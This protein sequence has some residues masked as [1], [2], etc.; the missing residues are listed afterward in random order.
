MTQC[1]F[2][3]QHGPRTPTWLLATAGITDINMVFCSSPDH[4]H[5]HGLRWPL[6]TTWTTDTNIVPPLVDHGAG[7]RGGL[8]VQSFC[9]FQAVAH[10]PAPLFT[11]VLLYLLLR[12]RWLIRPDHYACSLK[13]A[14]PLCSSHG[15]ESSKSNR[16][17][18]YMPKAKPLAQ[19][20]QPQALFSNNISLCPPWPCSYPSSPPPHRY[21]CFSPLHEEV[22][23]GHLSFKLHEITF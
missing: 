7:V 3:W 12:N 17:S 14:A 20:N 13:K 1:D 16:S 2:K 10:H 21:L 11:T 6:E 22:T 15:R 8:E 9:E 5:E 18:N 4:S 19:G 23:L